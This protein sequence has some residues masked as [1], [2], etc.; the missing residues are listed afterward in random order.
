[1]HFFDEL[2]CIEEWITK[3]SI[4]EDCMEIVVEENKYDK[5]KHE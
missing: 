1:L 3:P 4:V 2:K 5:P